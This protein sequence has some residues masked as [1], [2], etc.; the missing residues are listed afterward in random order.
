MCQANKN[1]SPE[2][3]LDRKFKQER[4]SR[5]DEPPLDSLLWEE[6]NLLEMVANICYLFDAATSHLF[7]FF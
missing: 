2:L 7:L 3:S 6:A 5:A 1:H 4:M